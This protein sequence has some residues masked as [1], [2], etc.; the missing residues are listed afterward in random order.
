MKKIIIIMKEEYEHFIIC[1]YLSLESM[2][3]FKSIL[4]HNFAMPRPVSARPP[5][6]VSQIQGKHLSVYLSICLSVY[7]SIFSKYL[8]RLR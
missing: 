4:E 3:T 6:P 7:L 1:M 5:S 2:Y 8:L